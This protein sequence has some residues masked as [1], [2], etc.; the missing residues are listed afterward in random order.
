[1]RK[2]AGILMMLHGV[3]TIG[4]FVGFRGETGWVFPDEFLAD[5]LIGVIV[6]AVFIIAGGV[7]CLKRKYWI[8]SF[9]SSLLLYTFY[10]L[11]YFLPPYS[12][13][14]KVL[15]PLVGIPPIIFVCPRRS[16]WRKDPA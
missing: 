2:A 12:L 8:I 6:A 14:F 13:W 4:F 7:F 16:E 15:S 9:A 11:S 5:F 3:K 1:M 10:V